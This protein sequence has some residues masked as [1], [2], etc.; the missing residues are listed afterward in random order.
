MAGIYNVHV[1]TCI[2]VTDLVEVGCGLTL[3]HS[4]E[5]LHIDEL[6]GEGEARVGYTVLRPLHHMWQV[7]QSLVPG[8]REER[9]TQRM[10]E[11]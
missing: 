4:I 1:Y 9:D 5:V 2:Y 6:V 7:P 3:S 8:G 10:N 11:T